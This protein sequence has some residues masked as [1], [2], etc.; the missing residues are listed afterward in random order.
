MATKLKKLHEE[1]DNNIGDT[2]LAAILHKVAD[3][4]GTE[5]TEEDEGYDGYTVPELRDL[6]KE[7]DLSTK[8]NK[9]ELVARLEESDEGGSDE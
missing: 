4:G 7:R 9:A 8:G 1:I 2:G 6:C 5:P 3:L